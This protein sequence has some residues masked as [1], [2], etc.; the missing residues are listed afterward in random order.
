MMNE[1]SFTNGAREGCAV[2]ETGKDRGSSTREVILDTAQR[3][4]LSQGYHGTSMRQIAE[5][6]DIA[7]SG[8]YNHFDGKEAMFRALLDRHQPYPEIVGGLGKIERGGA[9]ET[10]EAAARLIAEEA[11]SDVS[12]VRLVFIDL[13]EFNGDTVFVL[14]M[15]MVRGLMTLMS[16]LVAAG[17]LRDNIPLP[18]LVR[19]FVGL[20]LFYLLSESVAVQDGVTRS[21]MPFRLDDADIDWIGGMV[22]IFLNGAL[23]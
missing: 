8:I 14:A 21:E 1:R 23:A 6:A 2:T 16:R 10:L 7:V 11:I 15:Q 12:F 4:I 5:D 3:L 9:P 22:D 17:Q 19:S 20:V 18:V 13:Q